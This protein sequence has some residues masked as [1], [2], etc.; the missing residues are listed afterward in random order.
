MH[1]PFGGSVL[2]QTRIGSALKHSNLRV[3]TT[4]T[5]SALPVHLA[6]S[7]QWR[8]ASS[9]GWNDIRRLPDVPW[10][11]P[12]MNAWLTP[13]D[14]RIDL[15]E[16]PVD[17]SRLRFIGCSPVAAGAAAQ[18]YAAQ[19]DDAL[20]PT[21][22]RANVAFRRFA[23]HGWLSAS[24]YWGSGWAA[25]CCF[26]ATMWWFIG[27]NL[28]RLT[29]WVSNTDEVV[30]LRRE[31]GEDYIDNWLHPA[32]GRAGICIAAVV[33]R[34]R[35]LRIGCQMRRKSTIWRGVSF[36]AGVKSIPRT[37][38]YAASSLLRWNRHHPDIGLIL[39]DT[40][41]R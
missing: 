25:N 15:R 29:V 31:D 7:E 37:R 20:E 22:M 9:F 3:E 35:T 6:W 17:D 27:M 18:H 41:C 11:K 40:V 1:L 4:A 28:G 5:R 8:P 39:D 14:R 16:R 36:E 33:P 34:Q 2:Q 19:R 12:V 23:G 21:L 30:V 26:W 13:A 38:W 10:W 32:E 24:S